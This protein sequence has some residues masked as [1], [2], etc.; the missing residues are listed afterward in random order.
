[1][2][3][4]TQVGMANGCGS[5]ALFNNPYDV[6]AEPASG[7]TVIY[8]V[9]TSNCQVRVVN[10]STGC[11][12]TLAGGPGGAPFGTAA[13]FADGAA[14]AALFSS[15]VGVVADGQG[16]VF[17][18]D[19][20]NYKVRVVRAATG[21]TTTLAG[22]GPAGSTYGPGY[23]VS[24]GTVRGLALIGNKV[25]VSHGP[26]GIATAVA[27]TCI[28]SIAFGYGTVDDDDAIVNGPYG[29]FSPSVLLVTGGGGGTG[30]G[31]ANGIGTQALFNSIIRIAAVRTVIYV[32]DSGNNLIRRFDTVTGAV[33]TAAGGL[34]GTSVGAG[35]AV[36]TVFIPESHR[37]TLC[38]SSQAG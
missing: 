10:A 26:G 35:D 8:V 17:V 9:D 3:S 36:E 13:G 33:T 27:V 15:P 29:A 2:Y 16:N 20:N 1:M 19:Q 5:S 21:L 25:Y 31:F 11:V 4:G 22:G 28:S 14:S 23:N 12:R 24:L 34:G 32:A 18:A 38:V 6:A 30:A 7:G 37:G